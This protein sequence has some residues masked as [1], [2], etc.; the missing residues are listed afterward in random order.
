MFVNIYIL[1]K[2]HTLQKHFVS[3]WRSGAFKKERFQSK[4]E[5]K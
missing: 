5:S 3:K 2:V 1:L 4:E